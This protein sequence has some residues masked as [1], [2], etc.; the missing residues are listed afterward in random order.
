MG[1]STITASEKSRTHGRNQRRRP[2]SWLAV[3]VGAATI[4]A[5][6]GVTAIAASPAGAATPGIITTVAGGDAP[7]PVPATNVA[8]GGPAGIAVQGGKVYVTDNQ[9]HVV[10]T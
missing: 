8:I 3:T 9:F 2:R 10:R 7:G 5:T 6:L 1:W 4:F